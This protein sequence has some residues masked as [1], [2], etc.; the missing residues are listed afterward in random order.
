M[1]AHQKDLDVL[2]EQLGGLNAQ[3]AEK[4]AALSR[5][6]GPI[7][8]LL[9]EKYALQKKLDQPTLERCTKYLSKHSDD[10]ISFILQS[11]IGILRG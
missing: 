9:D 2:E 6:E 3:L 1:T 5:V 10:R 11:L 8:K 7:K 4:Q